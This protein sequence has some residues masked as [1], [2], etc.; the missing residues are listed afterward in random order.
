MYLK[1]KIG[2]AKQRKEIKEMN[3]KEKEVKMVVCSGKEKM[4]KT[5]K[6]QNRKCMLMFS[7]G[8]DTLLC[9][10]QLISLGFKP[11]S[12]ITFDNGAEKGLSNAIEN[13]ERLKKIYGESIEFLGI[14]SI[15]GIWRKFLIPYCL[16]LEKWNNIQLLPTERICLTCRTSMYIRAITECLQRD[17]PYLAEG[18]RESQGYPE[19]QPSIVERY[20]KLC[21]EFSIELVLPIWTVKNKGEVKEKLIMAGIIPK[22]AE[23]FCVFAMPLYE[24]QIK[25]ESNKG[26][27]KSA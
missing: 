22:T 14:R 20:K 25:N 5:E 3:A 2:E 4:T 8:Y 19:Q 9:V 27:G 11:I 21:K 23:P 24:Y 10:P 6:T 1:N 17:I 12:L 15:V 7:G 18:A 13:T 16:G 26:D